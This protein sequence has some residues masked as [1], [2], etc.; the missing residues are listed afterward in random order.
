MDVKKFPQRGKS[1]SDRDIYQIL[2]SLDAAQRSVKQLPALFRPA[3][4]SPQL[5]G[6]YPGRNAT[7][8][9]MVGEGEESENP[10]AQAVARRIVNQHPEL[11]MKYGPSEVMQ[12]INDVI[13]GDTDWEEIG[14]SDVSAYVEYVKDYLRDHHGAREEMDR[15]RPFA[16]DD[17]PTHR[18]GRD[19]DKEEIDDDGQTMADR[20]RRDGRGGDDLD[21]AARDQVKR[22]FKRAGRPVGEV[23]IDPD[24]IGSPDATTWYIKHYASGTDLG[25]YDSYEEAVEELK[26]LVK[27]GVSESLRAG[28]YHLATVTLDDGST[29]QIKIR[30]DE[31]FREPIER[32]FARQ[33][34]RVTDIDVD[35]SVRSDMYEGRDTAT[36]DVLS[37]M[38][39]KLGDYLQDVATAIK[40]DPDLIDQIPG[41]VDQI[42]AVKTIRTDDG[43]E[44]KIHGTEDD[45]FRISIKNK[46]LKTEFRDLDEAVLAAEMYCARRRQQTLEA[47]YIDEKTS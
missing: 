22:V 33:G 19:D 40:K 27:Q 46:N 18:D 12:A 24:G 4:T 47:D 14:S 34:R 44:I 20:A 3:Q 11:L 26:H 28:E 30:S 16:E 42:R 36:E 43:H 15:R 5:S 37:T 17:E 10:M 32:H 45:G 21:E 31:D 23:G 29:H 2:E 13:E 41:T 25:G 9:Y 6:R 39:K 1:M 35:Y 38:K 8:G 7:L